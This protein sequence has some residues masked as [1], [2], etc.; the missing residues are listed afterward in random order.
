MNDFFLVS[1]ILLGYEEALWPK[2]LEIRRPRQILT[3]EPQ[4]SVLS[5]LPNYYCNLI[6]RTRVWS[7]TTRGL[8]NV[9]EL[10]GY[11]TFKEMKIF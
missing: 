2:K 8:K 6:C 5:W 4:I 1:K 3:H 10:F 7:K 9:R 11:K